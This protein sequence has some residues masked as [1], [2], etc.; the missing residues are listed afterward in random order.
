[1]AEFSVEAFFIEKKHTRR[2]QAEK[3]ELKEK[4]AKSKAKVKSIWRAGT[5]NNS[6]KDIICIKKK[7]SLW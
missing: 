2:Y 5:T 6:I 3:L 7:C 1:M 4:V